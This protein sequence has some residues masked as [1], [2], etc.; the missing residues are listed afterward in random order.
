MT[1]ADGMQKVLVVSSLL[2][3]SC[4]DFDSFW[5]YL[6]LASS[7]ASLIYTLF[8][9]GLMLAIISLN[10]LWVLASHIVLLDNSRYAGEN[11]MMKYIKIAAMLH[12]KTVRDVALRCRWLAV[13][14]L[15]V[16]DDGMQ[17]LSSLYILS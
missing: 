5:C 6:I 9:F 15:C 13:S 8:S 3:F 14:Y 16:L 4:L 11:G 2:F 10:L 17:L 1:M 7:S 12:R